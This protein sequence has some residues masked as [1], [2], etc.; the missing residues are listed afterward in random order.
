MKRKFIYLASLLAL[1]S[2]LLFAQTVS[3]RV[4]QVSHS[5]VDPDGAGPATGSVTIKFELMASA[6]GIL[7]DGISL[8]FVFQSAKLMAVAPTTNTTVKKGPL[9]AILPAWPQTVDNEI[10]NI[11][12]TPVVYGGNSYD[13]RMIINFSEPSGNP[14]LPIPTTFT[15]FA[16]ITYWT[17]TTTFPQGGFI[18]AEP[19]SILPQNELSAEGGLASYPY[20]SPNLNLAA[21]LGTNVAPVQFSKFNATCNDKGASIQWATAQEQNTKSFDVE[22][23]FDGNNWKTIATVK[24][25]G[26]SSVEKN[27]QQLDLNAGAAFYRLK[28]IDSDGKISYT[29]I[30]TTTCTPK[31]IDMVIYPVPA[32][33]VLNISISSFKNAKTTLVIYD[34]TGKQV[35]IINENIVIGNN[36]FQ[37]NLSGFVSGQYVIRSLDE[38]ININKKFTIL[39]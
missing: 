22:K 6:A 13:R 31:Q 11:L 12:S 9:A 25:A 30:A 34:A 16:E 8:S 38:T 24:A 17:K 19:G 1:S 18:A 36:N 10:G 37:L 14:N 33:D 27:Y 15:S 26:N 32:K 21:P 4:A 29:S 39:K 5:V 7:A 20:L 28:Q 3:M 2:N 35:K 23:S